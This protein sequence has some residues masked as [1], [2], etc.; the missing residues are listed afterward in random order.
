MTSTQRS[1]IWTY[2]PLTILVVVFVFLTPVTFSPDI[3]ADSIYSLTPSIGESFKIFLY[4]W[5][6]ILALSA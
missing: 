2:I 6:F 5:L 3:L 4:I 1:T